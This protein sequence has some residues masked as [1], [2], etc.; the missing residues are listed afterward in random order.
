MPD[1][2]DKINIRRY[3]L[4]IPGVLKL[5]KRCLM[6]Y[7]DMRLSEYP[8]YFIKLYEMRSRPVAKHR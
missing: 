1:T 8:D 2:H 4:N 5:H 3:L 6:R 7:L